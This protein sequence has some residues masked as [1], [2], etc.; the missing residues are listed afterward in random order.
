MNLQNIKDQM[1]MDAEKQK[2][3]GWVLDETKDKTPAL[4]KASMCNKKYNIYKINDILDF[5]NREMCVFFTIKN[6][7]YL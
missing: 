3:V 7:H 1:T 6:I 5:Y 2:R 4:T